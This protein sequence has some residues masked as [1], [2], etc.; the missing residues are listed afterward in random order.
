MWIVVNFS[1]KTS[2]VL[3]SGVA[4]EDLEGPDPPPLKFFEIQFK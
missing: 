1:F 4:R 2:K 3:K